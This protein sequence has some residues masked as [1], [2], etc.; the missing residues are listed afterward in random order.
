MYEI[1]VAEIAGACNMFMSL[2]LGGAVRYGSPRVWTP[3]L[4]L[5]AGCWG[6]SV[7]LEGGNCSLLFPSRP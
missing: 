2:R 6:L 4:T 5:C 3:G 7:E 1:P